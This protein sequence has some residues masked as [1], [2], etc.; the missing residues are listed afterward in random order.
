M[1]DTTID[2]PATVPLYRGG[3]RK[4]KLSETNRAK[5]HRDWHRR[6]FIENGYSRASDYACGGKRKEILTRD[7]YKCVQCGM[8]D[9]QHKEKWGRPITVDHKDKNRKNNTDENLQTLCLSCH[10]RKDITQRLIEAKVFRRKGQ[11][12][13]MRQDGATYQA[14]A[15]ATGFSIGAVWKWVQRWR[16]IP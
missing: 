6:F 12:M 14:I 10:G 2:L 1:N 15:D 5:W 13:A 8:T 4:R 16:K 7:V 11:I 9:A 3:N